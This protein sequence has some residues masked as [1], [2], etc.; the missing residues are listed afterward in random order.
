VVCRPARR[1][2]WRQDVGRPLRDP[3]RDLLATRGGVLE[4]DGHTEAAVDL[5][6]LAGLSGVTAICEIVLPDGS[7]A[8]YHDLA[9]LADR[10]DLVLISGRRPHRLP[11]VP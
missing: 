3:L 10:D 11:H 4:R 5:S 6:R 8:R 1:W 7:M 9:Q 2:A